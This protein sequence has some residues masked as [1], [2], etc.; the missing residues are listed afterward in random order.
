MLSR[1]RWFLVLIVILAAFSPS[2][3]TQSGQPAG[4]TLASRPVSSA[5]RVTEAP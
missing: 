4:S 3:S 5:S 1:D 2:V